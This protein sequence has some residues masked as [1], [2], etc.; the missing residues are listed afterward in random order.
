MLGSC[1]DPTSRGIGSPGN[2]G[3]GR[4]DKMG[5]CVGKQFRGEHKRSTLYLQTAIFSV[6]ISS[7]TFSVMSVILVIKLY[8]FQHQLSA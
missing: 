7:V 6:S 3:R 8:S 5:R 4:I 2:R 1:S